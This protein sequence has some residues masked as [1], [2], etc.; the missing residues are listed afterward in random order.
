MENKWG[1]RARDRWIHWEAI[2]LTNNENRNCA[3]GEEVV[4]LGNLM[5]EN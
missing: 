4:N 1:R 2:Y 3:D 5:K